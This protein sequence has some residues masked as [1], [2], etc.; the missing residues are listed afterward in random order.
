MVKSLAVGDE[1]SI[2]TPVLTVAEVVLVLVVA[3]DL[4]AAF[5][6]YLVIVAV[7]VAIK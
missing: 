3:D 1:G 2:L 7:Q 4:A 5:L 6:T